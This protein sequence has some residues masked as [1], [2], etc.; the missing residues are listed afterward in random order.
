[1]PNGASVYIFDNRFKLPRGIMECI[2][3]VLGELGDHYVS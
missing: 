2:G 3:R 1:M